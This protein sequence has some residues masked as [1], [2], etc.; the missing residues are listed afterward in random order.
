MKYIENWL[1]RYMTMY[2]HDLLHQVLAVMVPSLVS[3]P[4]LQR[5]RTTWAWRRIRLRCDN[6]RFEM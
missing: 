1:Y 2:A 4:V 5:V 6:L 3:R